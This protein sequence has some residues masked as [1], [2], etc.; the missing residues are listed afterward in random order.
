MVSLIIYSHAVG[1]CVCVCERERERER[2]TETERERERERE[3]CAIASLQGHILVLG[4]PKLT[5]LHSDQIRYVDTHTDNYIRYFEGHEASVT[6]LI[7]HPGEDHFI[8]CSRDDTVRLWDLSTRLW[9]GRLNLRSAHLVAYDPSGVTFAVGSAA[10]GSVLMYDA[11]QF[12]KAPFATFDIVAACRAVDPQHVM[13]G[14]TKLEFSNNG[15]SLLVGTRGAGHF[16]LD[17]FTGA[18]VA[19]LAKP[20]GSGTRR[21]APGEVGPTSR[22]AGPFESS[23]DCAFSLDGM[24]VLS[25]GARRDMLVWDLSQATQPPPPP[26]ALGATPDQLREYQQRVTLQPSCVLED[27]REAAVLAVNPRFNFV[28]TADEEVLFWVPS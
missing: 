26:L 5:N 22:S 4:P 13:Q 21:L 9:T 16:V 20:Q 11:R 2:E 18:L 1:V 14:W 23:G 7:M 8:T 19:Y 17:A 28:A 6:S 25:G 24:H 10:S 27:Q 3:S 15:R 12:D